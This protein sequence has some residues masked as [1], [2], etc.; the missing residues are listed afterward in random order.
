M[1]I[2]FTLV[3]SYKDQEPNFENAKNKHLAIKA[4]ELNEFKQLSTAAS[5]LG[6]NEKMLAQITGSIMVK[7]D[8]LTNARKINIG[9]QMKNR[10]PVREKN[11]NSFN[12]KS[13]FK[14]FR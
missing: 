3:L 7:P 13:K 9:L 11:F 5:L 12:L 10:N 4:D 2:C 14:C 1:C 8:K 6:I